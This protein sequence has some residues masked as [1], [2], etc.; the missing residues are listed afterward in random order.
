MVDSQS[1][2]VRN[3]QLGLFSALLGL[4]GVIANDWGKVPC[5]CTSAYFFSPHLYS[6]PP[7][8]GQKHTH[9]HTPTY[10]H[11]HTNTH[12]LTLTQIYMDLHK[13]LHV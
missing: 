8:H 3:F 1:V 9:T 11:T 13:F 2:W 5:A 4:G 10:T 7:T 12:T 6:Y